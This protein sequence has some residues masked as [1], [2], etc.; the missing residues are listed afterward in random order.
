M[1]G[2]VDASRDAIELAASR[3]RAWFGIPAAPGQAESP[4]G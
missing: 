3:L 2:T 1:L 4:G